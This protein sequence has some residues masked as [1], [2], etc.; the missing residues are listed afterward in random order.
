MLALDF[1]AHVDPTISS[2]D[3][4]R[5]NA[6]VFAVTR[7]PDEFAAIV[8]RHHDSTLWGIGAHPG[9]PSAQEGFSREH[10]RDLLAGNAAVG[11]IGLDRRSLVPMSVQKNTFDA[12]LSMLQIQPKLVSVHS[13]GATRDVLELISCY[14]PEGIVLHWWRGSRTETKLAL[15]LGC[16]FS[17]N[18]AEVSRP[19][20]LS[21]LPS[22]RVL[23]ETDHPFGDRH[24]PTPHRPGRID[25]LEGY[26][27]NA[28]NLPIEGVRRR[29]WA[30]LLEL[31]TRA[32]AVDALPASF[33]KSL[34]A[35]G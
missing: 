17:I 26:L 14:R 24:E 35:V 15:D 2:I 4:D 19:K 9:V 10:F 29:V 25:A 31:A 30:N 6:C 32:A 28:W 34:L 5:L 22:E 27:S 1:H 23:T 11:E 3:L 20:I 7:T 33:R 16:Y 12:I 18:S 13:V 21:W 8:S